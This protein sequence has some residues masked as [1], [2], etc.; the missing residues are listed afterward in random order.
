MLRKGNSRSSSARERDRSGD[1]CVAEVRDT[2]NADTG[3]STLPDP[4][5]GKDRVRTCPT[6]AATGSGSVTEGGD[7]A[8][9]PTPPRPSPPPPPPM[10]RPAGPGRGQTTTADHPS[11]TLLRWPSFGVLTH[12]LDGARR[13]ARGPLWPRGSAFQ[14]DHGGGWVVAPHSR[15][16][17]A[18]VGVSSLRVAAIV[19]ASESQ[20]GKVAPSDR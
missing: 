3:Q 2:R 10:R 9:R 20:K 1:S 8:P 6:L 14:A 7:P 4:T 18:A 15:Q 12:V 19:R 16:T 13:I 5:S 11:K 17:T